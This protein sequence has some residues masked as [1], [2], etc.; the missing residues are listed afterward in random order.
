MDTGANA[1]NTVIH[2]GW[3]IRYS[4]QDFVGKETRIVVVLLDRETNSLAGILCG[5]MRGFSGAASS[6]PGRWR[7][8]ARSEGAACL[9]LQAAILRSKT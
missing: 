7:S 5:P 2:V 9:W 1:T 3:G 4:Q 6:E 8:A